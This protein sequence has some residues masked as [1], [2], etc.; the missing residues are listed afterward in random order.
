MNES[1]LRYADERDK[2]Y[3]IAGMAITIVA[4]DAQ[5]LLDGIDLDAEPGHTMRMASHFGMRGNPRM[6]AKILWEESVRDL[7][8]TTSMALGNLTSR[9]WVARNE[10]LSSG[11]VDTLRLAVRS[12]GA[13]HCDL[14]QDEADALFDHCNEYVS[15][16]FRHSGLPPVVH[17]FVDR[18]L[19][20]RS[21]TTAELID[22]LAQ[23]GLR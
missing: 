1:S 18:L 16:I 13:R 21:M 4:L 2:S 10:P 22:T 17:A 19:Q 15:R 5:D 6:S 9:R 20:Q 7:R 12:E 11:D 14:E 3:G 8:V 23:L